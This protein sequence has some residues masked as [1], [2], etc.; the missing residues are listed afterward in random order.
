[1]CC[2]VASGERRRKPRGL[3]HTIL[4]TPSH[5]HEKPAVSTAILSTAQKLARYLV[6]SNVVGKFA[7]VVCLS[8][9]A[10]V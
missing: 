9:R 5:S 1:M 7:E 8:R 3:R 6:R 4:Y 10:L 2:A